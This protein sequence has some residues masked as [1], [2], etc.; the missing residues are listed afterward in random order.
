MFPAGDVVITEAELVGQHSQHLFHLPKPGIFVRCG[1]AI[2]LRQLHLLKPRR[3]ER[4]PTHK[5]AIRVVTQPVADRRGALGNGVTQLATI[6]SS[7]LS[8]AAPEVSALG[9]TSGMVLATLIK[10]C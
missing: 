2:D 9:S 5:G 1:A 6:S 7:Q 3:D 10:V 4:V 8:R